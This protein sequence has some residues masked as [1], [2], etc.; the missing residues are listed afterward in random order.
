MITW[1]LI[2]SSIM[3]VRTPT[4]FYMVRFLLGVAEAGFFPG[5]LYYLSEWFPAPQRGRAMAGF[6][7]AI[8]LSVTIGG[9]LG[10]WLLGLDGQLG[11]RGWQWLFLIEGIPSVLLGLAALLYLTDRP[12]DARWLSGEQRAWLVERLQHDREGRA[13]ATQLNPLR[14]LV[15]PVLWLLSLTY[16][17]YLTIGTSWQFW[18]PTMVHDAFHASDAITGWI[19]GAIG[20]LTALAGLLAGASS[21]RSGERF[22]HAAAGAGLMAVGFVGLAVLPTPWGSVTG[23][24]VAGIGAR[25]FMP[26]FWCIPTL[27]LRGSAAAAGIALINSVG[28]IGGIVGPWAVGLFKDATGGTGGVFL[29]FAAL[30]LCASGLLLLLRGQKALASRAG[31]AVVLPAHDNLVAAQ[32]V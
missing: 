5:M 8:L 13:A 19:W 25:I 16:F 26:P 21:D 2:A 29:A 22:L 6:V 31:P 7:I 32:R 3:L 10:G 24:V 28:S 12:E 20:A 14:A 27:V 1:G 30:A 18:G 4:E 17:L 11:L 9:P 15:S 23:L